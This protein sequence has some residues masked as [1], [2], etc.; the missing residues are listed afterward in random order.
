MFFG[1]Y[2]ILYYF[3]TGT[4]YTGNF[5]IFEL[6]FS[7]RI[8]SL[9]LCGCCYLLYC[10]MPRRYRSRSRSGTRASGRG[11]SRDR[12]DR[13]RRHRDHRDSLSRSAS[14]GLYDQ[15]EEPVQA[16]K[17]LVTSQQ[18]IILDLLSEHRAE[19]E[20]KIQLKSRRFS[21]KQIEKQYQ[22][23]AEFRDLAAKI[24]AALHASEVGR[25]QEVLSLLSTKLE[26]HEHDLIVADTSPHGWL[27]VAKLRSNTELPK[28]LRKKLAQVEKDLAHRR[29]PQQQQQQYGGPRKK[30]DQFQ[31]EGQS[32]SRRR[33]DQRLSP[34]EALSNAAKQLRQGTC[35]HCHKGLHY[36]RECPDFWTKVQES[37]AAKAKTGGDGD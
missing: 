2:F 1:S 14:R 3:G 12:E 7:L 5:P 10:R 9:L 22:I 24:T 25:A 32:F 23:N 18:E 13:R 17:K 15:P 33:P 28:T 29:P 6:V 16:I 4:K 34:E 19:V 8:Y 36:Y 21:S 30:F 26:D 20:E 31:R 27:A 37:R 11:R 35:T